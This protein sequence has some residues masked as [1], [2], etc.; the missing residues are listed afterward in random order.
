MPTIAQPF[1]SDRL[2]VLRPAVDGDDIVRGCGEMRG[3]VAADGTGAD[4]C[5]AFTHRT[6]PPR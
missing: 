3:N 6:I 1:R 4:N 2:D 5:D